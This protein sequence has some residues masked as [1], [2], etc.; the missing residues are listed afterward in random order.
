[1]L[2]RSAGGLRYD[3]ECDHER[4]GKRNDEKN[5]A[6]TETIARIVV[7]PVPNRTCQASASA[8]QFAK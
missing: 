8:F 5:L 3:P 4:V 1:M 6:I 2:D 7:P